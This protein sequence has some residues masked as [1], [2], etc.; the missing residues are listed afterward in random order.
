MGVAMCLFLI[1]PSHF[2]GAS[3]VPDG[4]KTRNSI[5]VNIKKSTSLSTAV[6][7]ISQNIFL[8]Q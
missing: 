6:E 3:Y 2:L 7:K 1:W 8:H 5:P 4:A